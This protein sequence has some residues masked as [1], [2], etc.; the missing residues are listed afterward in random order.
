MRRRRILKTK[1]FNRW[2]LR[3]DLSDTALLTAVKEIEQ[4]LIDG[5]LGAGVLKK[6]VGVPGRGKS[7]GARVVLATN[8]GDRW[9]FMFG[10][11]KSQRASISPRELEA[12]RELARDLL[13]LNEKQIDAQT[14]CGALEEVID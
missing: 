4:G 7:G 6:R 10:F 12:L 2:V 3:A 9:F 11:L 5:D 13:N 8:R 1:P 14:K